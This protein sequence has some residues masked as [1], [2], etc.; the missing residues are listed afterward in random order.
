MFWNS[1]VESSSPIHVGKRQRSASTRL[2]NSLGTNAIDDDERHGGG[3]GG[4][5]KPFGYRRALM[6]PTLQKQNRSKSLTKSIKLSG[7]LHS[8]KHSIDTPRTPLQK[9]FSF[10]QTEVEHQRL[11]TDSSSGSS[12][13]TS[14]SENS[15]K[16]YQDDY[17]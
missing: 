14:S 16:G 15:M 6:V 13:S 12:I 11:V 5:G 3:S 4:T 10:G 9:L 7:S 1:N 2:D 8:S 17:C